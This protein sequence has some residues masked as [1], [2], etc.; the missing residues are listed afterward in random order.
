MGYKVTTVQTH[1][2]KV[3]GSTCS[4]AP[5]AQIRKRGSREVSCL[6]SHTGG[7]QILV[8]RVTLPL[9]HLIT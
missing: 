4:V 2:T 8:G 3:A 6:K 9:Q 1:L 5:V 7:G